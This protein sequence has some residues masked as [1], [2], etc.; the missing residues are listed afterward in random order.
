MHIPYL[1][2][3]HLN[4]VVFYLLSCGHILALC[5]CACGVHRT[6]PAVDGAQRKLNIIILTF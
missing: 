3:F 5:V 4:F 1:L 2:V 6:A